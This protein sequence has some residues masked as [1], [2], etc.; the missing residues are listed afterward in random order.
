[1]ELTETMGSYNST[2]EKAFQDTIQNS[3]YYTISAFGGNDLKW[4]DWS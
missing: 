1:M 2:E 4:E 3:N